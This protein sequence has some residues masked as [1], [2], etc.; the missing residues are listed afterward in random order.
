[1]ARPARDQASRREEKALR[2]DLAA[3]KAARE[4][5]YRDC[6]VLD[7]VRRLLEADELAEDR[8]LFERVTAGDLSGTVSVEEA[9]RR[10]IGS[11][12]I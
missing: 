1:M 11:E 3:A 12:R 10:V 9:R 2:R 5:N 7:D 6:L 4:N 8:E